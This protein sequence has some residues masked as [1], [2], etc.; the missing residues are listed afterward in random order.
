MAST[1][2][3]TRGITTPRDSNP[4]PTLSRYRDPY[5]YPYSF[6]QLRLRDRRWENLTFQYVPTEIKD[7]IDVSYK[8]EEVAGG[9]ASSLVFSK[10]GAQTVSFQLFLNEWGDK[11][12]EFGWVEYAIAWLH[13]NS[14]PVAD[15]AP[16][17][18]KFSGDVT[19]RDPPVLELL[20][21][22][23][24]KVHPVY[25]PWRTIYGGTDWRGAKGAC[26]NI[27][28]CVISRMEITSQMLHPSSLARVRATIDMELKEKLDNP[29]S[30]SLTVR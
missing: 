21:G 17:A 15:V 25:N 18:W 8:E 2:D 20:G 6:M 23:W 7:K 9:K 16:G 13:R 11:R 1:Q 28:P 24:F 5:D 4:Q 27:F 26:A 3:I 19:F 14:N 10:V 30:S 29:A 22:P 12:R